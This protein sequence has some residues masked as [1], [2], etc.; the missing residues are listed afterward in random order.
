M[1]GIVVENLEGGRLEMGEKGFCRNL[2]VGYAVH[3]IT[4]SRTCV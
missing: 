3:H 1:V 2:H 4:H